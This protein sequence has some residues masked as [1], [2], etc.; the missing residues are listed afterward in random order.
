MT[1]LGGDDL[2][3]DADLRAAFG[4]LTV[5]G[6]A[7]PSPPSPRAVPLFPLVGLVVGALV[8]IVWW[9]G[10]LWWAPLLAA[11]VAVVA[12]AVLTGGLHL[13]GV[14]DAGDGLLAPLPRERRL[15]AM[16]EPQIGAFG[17]IAVVGVLLLRTAALAST[18]A[19]PLGV[20]ALL[21]ASRAVMG[22]VAATRPHARADGGLGGPLRG[23]S[24]SHLAVVAVPCALLP[25]L[26]GAGFVG[27]LAV[28]ATVA[29]AAAV[30]L[31]AQRRIGGWT[32]DVLGAA[33]VV[34]E[35]V[36]LLV[37]AVR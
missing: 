7:D 2:P 10:D 25:G 35:T 9:L 5:L 22:A 18:A 34:G 28:G 20:A 11:A 6:R 14:A 19:T 4:F 33:G 29:A 13:D 26:A 32:G 37:L 17:V 3:T 24:R 27:V 30:V 16:S 31:V 12:D 15:A 8:G 23:A 1:R 21:A 36:G